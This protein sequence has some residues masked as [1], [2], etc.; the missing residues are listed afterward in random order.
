[1]A[2]VNVVYGLGMLEMGVTLDFGQLVMD[3]EF[4]GMIKHVLNGIPVNDETLAVDVIHSVGPFKDFLGTEHTLKHMR[5][6]SQP[7]LI[8]RRRRPKWEALGETDIYRRASEKARH[9]L[10]TH[11][12]DPLPDSV[13]TEIR[14]IIEAAEK[15]LGVDKENQGE[16]KK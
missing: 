1:L 16:A 12:P 4:A 8:D 14:S 15:E 9:I 11:Q 10:E 13:L 7:Q 5:S 3:N 6:Q 2:G